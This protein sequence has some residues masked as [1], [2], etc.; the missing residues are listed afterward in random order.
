M[1]GREHALGRDARLNPRALAGKDAAQVQASR[2][3]SIVAMFRTPRQYQRWLATFPEETRED[4][5]RLTRPWCQFEPEA[6]VAEDAVIARAVS[7][8]ARTGG[9]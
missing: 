3:Q 4:V 5:R 2:L 7:V 9:A 1:R 8:A 6:I